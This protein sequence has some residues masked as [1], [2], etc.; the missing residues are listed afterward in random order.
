MTNIGHVPNLNTVH[1][2]EGK[3]VLPVPRDLHVHVEQREKVVMVSIFR[4]RMFHLHIEALRT[5]WMSEGG[6]VEVE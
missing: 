3:N 2:S 6:E 4:H 1:I 5:S